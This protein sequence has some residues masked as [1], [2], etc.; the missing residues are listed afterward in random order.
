MDQHPD[1]PGVDLTDLMANLDGLRQPM[2]VHNARGEK[3]ADLLVV[4]HPYRRKFNV[5]KSGG[6]TRTAV[7]KDLMEQGFV[8]R[9]GVRRLLKGRTRVV[10]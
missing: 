7:R 3:V 4:D 9:K 6:K 5:K 2:V 8:F 10:D 1:Y